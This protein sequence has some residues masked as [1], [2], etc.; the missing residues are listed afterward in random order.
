[1]VGAAEP[2]VGAG[3]AGQLCGQRQLHAAVQQR[4]VPRHSAAPSVPRARARCG[5]RARGG[6]RQEGWG[7]TGGGWEGKKK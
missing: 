5:E 2:A 4:H 6:G 1:M 3:A 7:L